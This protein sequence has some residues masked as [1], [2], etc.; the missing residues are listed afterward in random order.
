MPHLKDKAETY[1][2]ALSLLSVMFNFK[3]FSV[4]ITI[5]NTCLQLLNLILCMK[6]KCVS[7]S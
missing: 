3:L 7:Y 5:N 1:V 2:S 4:I 6:L